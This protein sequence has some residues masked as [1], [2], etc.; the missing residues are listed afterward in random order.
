MERNKG[1]RSGTYL[2]TILG[3]LGYNRGSRPEP[4]GVR[5]A[6]DDVWEYRYLEQRKTIRLVLSLFDV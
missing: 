1:P 5:R 4:A 2:L 3:V 6:L